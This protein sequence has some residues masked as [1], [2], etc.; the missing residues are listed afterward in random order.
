MSELPGID[1]A[2]SEQ[3]PFQ[4]LLNSQFPSPYAHYFAMTSLV[5]FSLGWAD[6]MEEEMD[7]AHRLNSM[8]T[9]YV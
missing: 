7:K 9:L 6:I 2:L 5:R 4:D 8:N 1:K 3:R